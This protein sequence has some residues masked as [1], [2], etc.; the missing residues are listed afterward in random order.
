MRQLHHCIV[1]GMALALATAFAAPAMGQS[2]LTGNAAFGDWRSDKPG[3]TRLIKPE[4]L[5]K[6]GAT[7][8]AANVSRVV[9][10][11]ASAVPQVPDGFKIGL[12]AEGLS[13]P[14]QMRVA[15]NGDIFV[16][17]TRSGR[18]RILR[19][20][21]GSSSPSANEAYAS[22]LNHPFG[23]A[24]FPN[25][26][27]P[28]WVYIAN[29]DSVVRFP[30][31]NGDLKAAGKPETVVAE[32]PRGGHSTRDIAFT[33]DNK[34]MLISVGSASN[35]AEG[36]GG[37]AGGTQSWSAQ[38]ALGESWGNETDRAAVLTFDPDGKRLGV[39]ATGIRNCVGLAIHPRTGDLYCS[40]NERD[41]FG[42]NLVPDYVTR[43]REGG[44]Y[45]WPW[46]Y[47]GSNEDPHHAGERPDLKGK[48]TVPDVLLQ[49]H[50]ASL[51][52]TFYSGSAF[53]ADYA[54]DGFAAEHGSWNRSKRT[55]YKVIRIRMK[56][57]VPSG[58]Y[59]DFITGF[60]INDSDVWGRPVGVAVAHDGALLVSE[61]GNGTIWRVTH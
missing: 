54:G 61:D 47:I 26:D 11:P 5:P 17:E 60:V 59:E 8:S 38:H 37:A 9:P 21:D 43:V 45:G 31:R 42:E 23:I 30:Y 34:R 28:Q 14:R 20:A 4:N 13:G 29:T 48:A 44:F 56:D 6:P 40:T 12:F 22:G 36:M 46:Y 53:P 33:P 7:P 50:S 15:P 51:G 18:I 55:G 27:N 39:F 16:A 1:N 58:E 24:F 49:A 35:D 3:V 10:R 57:G 25:G 41:G 52:L 19:A 32:L 2:P